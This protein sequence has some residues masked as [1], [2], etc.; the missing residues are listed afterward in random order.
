MQTNNKI[1][2][3]INSLNFGGAER[4]MSQ[5]INSLQGDFEIHLALYHQI[6]DY[7][8]PV[9]VKIIDLA[10]DEKNG[11][12]K[13]FLR[14]PL[15]AYKLKKYCRKHNIGTVVTFLNRACYI[16][17]LMKSWWNYKGRVVMCE[18]SYQSNILNVIGGGTEVYK[19]I[20]KKFISFSYQKADLVLTNSMLSKLDLINNFGITTPIEVIYNPIDLQDI[21]EK[22]REVP[23]YIFDKDSYYFISVGNFRP[24]KRYDILL[25]AIGILKQYPIKLILIGGGKLE[26]EF[27]KIAEENGITDK[28]IFTG[29]DNNPYKYISRANCFV[30]SSYTEG[31]PNVLL[32]ALACRKAVISTD[33]K[34]GPREL[35]APETNVEEEIKTGFEVMKYGVLTAVN[36]AESMAKAM[37][38]LYNDKT[39][40]ESLSSVA[41]ERAAMFDKTHISKLYGDAFVGK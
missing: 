15:I 2:F 25:K 14:L 5:L 35:L 8:I 38:D 21:E 6:F 19:K 20:S 3:V 24:E 17:A 28:V 37:L 1:L 9:S 4:V 16:A 40:Q 30:L 12:A 39:L 41:F 33:C 32:E 18:R 29:F 36:D 26:P 13:I 23:Q 10:E 11:N 7:K 34:S 31:F 22:S 27:K